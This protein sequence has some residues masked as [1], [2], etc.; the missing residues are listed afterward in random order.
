[1][2]IK[3]KIKIRKKKPFCEVKFVGEPGPTNEPKPLVVIVP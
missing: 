1:M 2:Y 3:A